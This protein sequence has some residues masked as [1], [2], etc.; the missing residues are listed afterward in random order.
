MTE[1][2]KI[3]GVIDNA[4]ES[5]FVKFPDVGDGTNCADFKL[6]RALA[7]PAKAEK[8]SAIQH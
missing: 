8:Q 2:D 5:A 1:S 6:T 7:T 3:R 4:I